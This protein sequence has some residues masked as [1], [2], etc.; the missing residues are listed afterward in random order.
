MADA[1]AAN[2]VE[3]KIVDD[4]VAQYTADAVQSPVGPS[5]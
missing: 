4:K 5:R 2:G 1:A 3:K